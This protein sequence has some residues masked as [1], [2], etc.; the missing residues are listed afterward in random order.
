M[1]DREKT[2]DKI[3]NDLRKEKTEIKSLLN[4]ELGLFRQDTDADAGASARE[5]EKTDFRFEFDEAQDTTRVPEHSTE[6]KRWWNRRSKKDTAQ[7]KPSMEFV[8]DE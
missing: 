5:E 4:R 2:A 3:R 1:V 6:K 7:N 8:I